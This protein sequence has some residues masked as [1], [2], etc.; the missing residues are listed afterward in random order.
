MFRRAQKRLR[1]VFE[2]GS[3]GR[4]TEAVNELNTL[5]EAI[6]CSRGSPGTTPA[7]G[8]CTSPA[9]APRSAPS[10]WP[11][12]SG[13]WRS[14]CASTAA[15]GSASAPTSGAA[16]STSTR[17]PTAAGG[18]ARS[19]AP[20][21]RTWPP[22]GPASAATLSRRLAGPRDRC[23]ARSSD[24][25]RRGQVLRGRTPAPPAGR[26]RGPR[27]SWR[28]GWRPPRRPSRV[29]PRPASD[30]SSS[31]HGWLPR[32]GT[33]CSSRPSPVPSP[34]CTCASPSPIASAIASA[35][36]RAA[37]QCDRSR[38][39]ASKPASVGSQPGCVGHELAAGHPHRVHVLDREVGCRGAGARS[40]RARRRTS[41]A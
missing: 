28:P 4:D 9:A 36:V 10:T 20:P 1:D 22:T 8:T 15:P 40:A 12:R 17:R 11:A 31:P 41:R 34:R 29:K 14:G 18:S 13:A 21:G 19:A 37:A 6:R 38:V 30:S 33:R 3:A 25:G 26:P 27:G 39:Y 23:R 32:P 24:S 7:T 2:L 5:L 35:S 16:T